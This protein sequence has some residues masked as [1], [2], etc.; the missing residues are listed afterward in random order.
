MALTV[1]VTRV[2]AG[3]LSDRYGRVVVA[4]PG[5][6]LVGIGMFVEAAASSI[7]PLVASAIL[8]GAGFGALFP[9]LMAFAVDRVPARE[10]GSAM[11]TYT[12]AIDL[13]IGAGA[14]LLGAVKGAAGYPAMY[15]VSGAIAFIGVAILL[16]GARDPTRASPP[17][18]AGSPEP[19]AANP[20]R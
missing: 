8:F 19:R 16:V 6:A 15:V 18:P 13:G 2:V 14:P 5:L 1:I 20:H 11:A 12:A 17:L 7:V 4:A 9:T 3:R 10:R